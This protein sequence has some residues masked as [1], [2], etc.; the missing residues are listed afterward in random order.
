MHLIEAGEGRLKLM[1]GAAFLVFAVL[2]IGKPL[3]ALEGHVP[4]LDRQLLL[5]N[6]VFR[7][8]DVLIDRNNVSRSRQDSDPDSIVRV[9][10]PNGGERYGI[11]DT[12]KVHW[13]ADP[14][15]VF[16]LLVMLSPDLGET[17]KLISSESIENTTGS[18]VFE[19]VI[20]P[21][22]DNLSLISERCLVLVAEYFLPYH[23]ISDAP[24]VIVDT[25]GNARR[26]SV[27]PRLREDDLCRIH[28]RAGRVSIR[29]VARGEHRVVLCDIAGSVLMSRQ[30][31]GPGVYTLPAHLL[32]RACAI[33]VESGGRWISRL[34]TPR[35]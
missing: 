3:V 7:E 11:G 30:G 35:R 34:L 33:R 20:E 5:G 6:P 8:R 21:E 1:D 22:I 25:T 2:L 4:P 28:T 14:E 27:A 17:W 13:E 16:E 31:S 26:P 32:K 15:E 12:L 29:V 9:L 10:A 24:F 19:W 23:D 18:G